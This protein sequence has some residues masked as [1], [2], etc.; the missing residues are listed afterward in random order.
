[1]RFSERCRFYLREACPGAPFL[2]HRIHWSASANP[3][4]LAAQDKQISI[5]SPTMSTPAQSPAISSTRSLSASTRKRASRF[6][7]RG[8]GG[9]RTKAVGNFK[10]TGQPPQTEAGA[11]QDRDRIA[12]ARRHVHA[13]RRVRDA[14]PCFRTAGVPLPLRPPASE[15][16]LARPERRSV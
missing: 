1:R 5:T 4:A 16:Q 3:S 7:S 2:I 11:R 14:A 13:Y 15:C 8:C 6:F 10:I 12:A 9:A